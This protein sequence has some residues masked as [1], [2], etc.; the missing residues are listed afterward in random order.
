MVIQIKKARQRPTLSP[1]IKGNTIS[2]GELDFRVRDG[3]G[4]GFSVMA[5]EHGYINR[6]LLFVNPHS[7]FK[8]SKS[9]SKMSSIVGLLVR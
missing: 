4:Y 5:T 9:K 6:F 3:N 1:S 2:T 8:Y 7:K